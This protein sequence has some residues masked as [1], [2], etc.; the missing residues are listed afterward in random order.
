MNAMLYR[1]YAAAV[2]FD[3]EDRIFIGR[4]AEV[5]EAGAF[6]NPAVT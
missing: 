4:G 3:A 1:S 2:E 6:R 5:K